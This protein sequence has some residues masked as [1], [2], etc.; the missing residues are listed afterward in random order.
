MDGHTDYL[1]ITFQNDKKIKLD[2]IN[3]GF[4]HSNFYAFSLERMSNDGYEIPQND[5][6]LLE[7][8]PIK[9]IEL[10]LIGADLKPITISTFKN[11]NDKNYFIN[12]FKSTELL[13]NNKVKIKEC[14]DCGAT[15]EK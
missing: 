8:Q 11:K 14:F 2:G 4:D 9:E 15:W 13:N 3:V 5:I 6:I 1:C 12:V 7:T 10:F